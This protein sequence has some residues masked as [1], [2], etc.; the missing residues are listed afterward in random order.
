MLLDYPNIPG[1]GEIEEASTL[2]EIIRYIYMFALGAAGFVALLAILIGAIMYIFSAGNSIIA[3]NKQKIAAWIYLG[4]MIFNI[5]T[6]LIFIP[7]YSYLE[8]L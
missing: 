2:P 4:G 5:V 1:A 7:K 6:N 3:L 8:Q